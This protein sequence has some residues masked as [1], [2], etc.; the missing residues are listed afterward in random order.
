MT[1][2]PV[3]EALLESRVA[4]PLTFHVTDGMASK[5]PELTIR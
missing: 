3:R 4:C 5:D 1:V 2:G